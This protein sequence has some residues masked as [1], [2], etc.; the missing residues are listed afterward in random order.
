MS[1]KI[2]SELKI[3]KIGTFQNRIVMSAMTRGFADKD[4]CAT[5]EILDYYKKRA[6]NNVG[7][8]IT[9]GIIVHPSGDGYNNVPHLFTNEQML[10]WKKVV[11]GVH[12]YK[13]KIYAQLWHC[14]RI[15]HS[16]YTNGFRIY[17]RNSCKVILNK[18]GRIGDGFIILSE[19]L[20]EINNKKLKINEINSV[21]INRIRGES[22]VG[23]KT[24]AISLLGL[25]KL[26]IKRIK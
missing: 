15:S 5:T 8:I 12:K 11:D 25:L 23:I 10:S 16:D 21:F 14:G 24:F 3:D 17:S 7:L 13:T 18:C 1:Y 20:Q 4:H 19:I 22:S 2:L 26:F 9:E 6:K